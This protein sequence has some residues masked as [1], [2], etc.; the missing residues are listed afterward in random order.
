MQLAQ[1]V[2]A[3]VCAGVGHMATNYDTFDKL[4]SLTKVSTKVLNQQ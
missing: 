2:L 3:C 4:S 1:Y